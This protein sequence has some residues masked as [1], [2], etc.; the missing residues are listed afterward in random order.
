MNAS[1]PTSQFL[2]KSFAIIF[3]LVLLFPV[4]ALGANRGISITPLK[5]KGGKSVLMYKE[6]HAL[7]IGI[8]KYTGGWPKLPGVK[9]DIDAVTDALKIGGFHVVVVEDPNQ[10]E[11]EAAFKNFVLKYG[12]DVDNRLFFYFAGHGYTHKPSYAADDPEEWMGYIVSREAPAPQGN[13]ANFFRH[14]LSMQRIEELALKIEAKHAM[15]VFDSCFSGSIFA[16]SR[17]IPMDIQER[18]AKPVRQFISAGSA[19]QEVPDV[20]IFRRQFVS[21]LEGE[22]DKNNDGYVTGTELGLFLEETVTNLSKRTQTPQYGK[23]RHRRLNKGD[24]VF[25]IQVASLAASSATVSDASDL[26]QDVSSGSDIDSLLHK[27]KQRKFEEVKKKE[28]VE[29]QYAKLREL[30]T[31]E[32]GMVTSEQKIEF[33]EEFVKKYPDNNLHLTEANN[34]I[35]FLKEQEKSKKVRGL[36][37]KEMFQVARL[38]PGAVK[39]KPQPRKTKLVK[40]PAG[41]FVAGLAGKTKSVTLK[42]FYIDPYEVTQAEYEKM[43][44]KNPSRFKGPD[45][46][47]EK[48]NWGEAAEYCK[49]MGKRLPTSMEWE[50]AARAGTASKYYWGDILGINHANC[51]GC[52]SQWDGLSTAPVGTFTPNAWGI[53]D[54]SGNVWEWVTDDYDDKSKVLR[55]G[56]WVDD[57]SFV[58]SAGFYFI[59]PEN[60]SYDIGFRCAKG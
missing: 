50:K 40:V 8:S 42:E 21:G 24:F 4:L 18:T 16:V 27:A 10:E 39:S 32:E 56:S 14:A 3:L 60:R 2:K 51:D 48:V 31:L 45:K 23:I 46:P 35:K 53:Y 6:S 25:P 11:L 7:V 12:L 15:F 34:T 43:M 44:G 52:G 19:D 58:E 59:P 29:R 17:A 26:A 5:G 54:M 57:S 37:S 38:D 22:A 41:V 28:E 30:E 13:K 9:K 1:M 49:R 20:S 33:W 36:K 47:V 55:G